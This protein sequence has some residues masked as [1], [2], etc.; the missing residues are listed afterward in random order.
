MIYLVEDDA[1]IRELVIYALNQ[2]GFPAEGFERP[3]AFWRALEQETPALILLDIMLPEEDGL[4]ILKKLRAAAQTAR[5]PVMMLTAKGSEYDKV[6]GLELGADDYL[7]KPFGMMELLARVKALLRRST[8]AAE[9][10]TF[11]LADLRICPEQHLVLRE[12]QPIALTKKEFE[13]LCT[14]LR[15]RGTVLTRDRLLELVWGYSFEGGSRTVD[16]HIRTL[17]QKLGQA[18]DLIE[19]VRGIGYKIG[20]AY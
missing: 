6:L 14:L 20:G 10:Q 15:S 8:P 17:R 4:A 12:G 5:T 11:L 1:D 19:T 18:G 16:V 13:L 9:Q 7:P 3:S 2:S